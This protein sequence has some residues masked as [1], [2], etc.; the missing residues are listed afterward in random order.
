[1]AKTSNSPIAKRARKAYTLLKQ[2]AL[3][4][5]APPINVVAERSCKSPRYI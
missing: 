5:N 2:N 1:M 3:K 4:Q